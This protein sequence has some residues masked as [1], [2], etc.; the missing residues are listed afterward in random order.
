MFERAYWSSTKL[1]WLAISKL[2]F[3]AT[4]EPNAASRLLS[5]KSSQ[6]KF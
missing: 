3:E 1:D 4:H 6:T 2:A 5:T